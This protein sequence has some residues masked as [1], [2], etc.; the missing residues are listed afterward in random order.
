VHIRLPD[1]DKI[2]NFIKLALLLFENIPSF[3]S[4]IY[5]YISYK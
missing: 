3:P 2:D 4:V 5:V 1:I